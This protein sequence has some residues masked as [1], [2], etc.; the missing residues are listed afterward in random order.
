MAP[1]TNWDRATEGLQLCER[2]KDLTGVDEL[3]DQVV[4]ILCQMRHLCRLVR[5][6][7]GEVIDFASCLASSQIHFEAEVE[8]DEDCPCGGF[9]CSS[10]NPPVLN[11]PNRKE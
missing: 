5:D 9:D 6:E 8:E 10:A 4:D 1:R 2:M 7:E 3:R 11:C